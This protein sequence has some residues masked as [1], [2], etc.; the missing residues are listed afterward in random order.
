MWLPSRNQSSGVDGIRQWHRATQRSG[1]APA[2]TSPSPRRRTFGAFQTFLDG[3]LRMSSRILLGRL[4]VERISEVV[5]GEAYRCW[6]LGRTPRLQPRQPFSGSYSLLP[7]RPLVNVVHTSSSLDEEPS[8]GF[9]VGARSHI[10]VPNV[11]QMSAASHYTSTRKP[12]A[13]MVKPETPV[14]INRHARPSFSS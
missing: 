3:E 5:R 13:Q 7:L 2:D 6:Q 14:L 11:G 4:E 10:I 8:S 9:V 12:S 1:V